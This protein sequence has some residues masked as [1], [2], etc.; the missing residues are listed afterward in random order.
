MDG[1]ANSS[2]SQSGGGEEDEKR[3][4]QGTDNDIHCDPDPVLNGCDLQNSS[5]MICWSTYRSRLLDTKWQGSFLLSPFSIKCLHQMLSCF[6]LVW[7]KVCLFAAMIAS[8]LVISNM[9]LSV[10]LFDFFSL[11]SSSEWLLYHIV[12]LLSS[13]K[14]L[15]YH[16]AM[17][18]L[19]KIISVIV[20]HYWALSAH[21]NSASIS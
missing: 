9:I 8:W 18:S 2:D 4:M 14:W 5:F 20:D 3:R 15:S 19:Y 1:R 21:S 7:F 6:L 11:L 10:L 16:I 12:S 17:L 13:S